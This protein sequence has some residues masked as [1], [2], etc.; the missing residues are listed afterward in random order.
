MLEIH[1]MCT[2]YAHATIIKQK[3]IFTYF[4]ILL[5]ALSSFSLFISEVL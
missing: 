1:A 5:T 2:V 3:E 4:S